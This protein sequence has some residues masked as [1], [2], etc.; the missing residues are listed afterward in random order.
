ME[1]SL[2]S[3]ATLQ[4]AQECVRGFLLTSGYLTHEVGGP[5]QLRFRQQ[6]LGPAFSN[7]QKSGMILKFQSFSLLLHQQFLNWGS[8]INSACSLAMPSSQQ[9]GIL[10][11]MNQ[12]TSLAWYTKP[13]MMSLWLTQPAVSDH[14]SE[15]SPQR[16][17]DGPY[18]PQFT[19]L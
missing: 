1:Q 4:E 10:V 11:S 9:A 16:A 13:T 14:N 15:L 7:I 2:V 8:Q 5:I 12:Y 3:I 17:P 6:Y 19:Y 18:E